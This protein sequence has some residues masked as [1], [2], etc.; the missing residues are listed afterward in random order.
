MG[1]GEITL[2]TAGA[3]TAPSVMTWPA[4]PLVI[5]PAAGIWTDYTL[6]SWAHLPELRGVMFADGIN[7]LRLIVEGNTYNAGL[8]APEDGPTVDPDGAQATSTLTTT[9]EFTDGDQIRLGK[10]GTLVTFKDTLPNLPGNTLGTCVKRTGTVANTLQNLEDLVMGTGVQ[11]VDYWDDS[12]A[13]GLGLAFADND[14]ITASATATTC[15]FTA[16][17]FGT[18][19]NG[20]WTSEVTDGGGGTFSFNNDPFM[21]SGAVTTSTGTGPKPGTYLWGFTSYRAVDG[22][23]SGMS[24][25]TED[26]VG[27]TMDVDLSDLDD[28]ADTSADFTRWYRSASG[29]GVLRLGDAIARGGGGTATDNYADVDL[30]G[31][32]EV[33]YDPSA[34]RSFNEGF[35]P[36][37]R[38]IARYQGRTFGGGAVLSAD[39]SIGTATVALNSNSVTITGGAVTRLWEGRT[40]TCDSKSEQYTIVSATPSTLPTWGGTLKLDR[41]YEV[42]G[43]SGKSYT[44]SD[45]RGRN[46]CTLFWSEPLQPSR[47]PGKNSL[48]AI[49]SSHPEGIMGMV[50]YQD[51]LV[52]FTRTGIWEVTPSAFSEFQARNRF[53]GVG[54]IS[55]HAIVNAEG[56]LYFA[57]EDGIYR[58]AGHLAAPIKVTSPPIT[59]DGTVSGIQTTWNRVSEAHA[60]RIFGH[61]DPQERVISWLLPLDGSVENNFRLNLELQTFTWS[62]DTIEGDTVMATVYDSDGSQVLL[63]GTRAGHVK[64]LGVGTSDGA[65]GVEQ[66]NTLT[67]TSTRTLTV[68]GASWTTDQFAG[69]PLWIVSADGDFTRATIASNTS[70]VLTLTE[71]IS[72]PGN[73][74]IVVGGILMDLETGRSHFGD[75]GARRTLAAVRVIHAVDEDGQYFL[76]SARDQDAADVRAIASGTLTA[77]DGETRFRAHRVGRFQKIRLLCIEPGCEPEF[78]GFELEV[79]PRDRERDL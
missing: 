20:Y 25:T 43:G 37:V 41:D 55:G 76:A 42:T 62:L 69:C 17:S 57:A 61:Y 79:R 40:F 19:G 46:T 50:P 53:E 45:A 75:P 29:S 24:P 16:T 14:D 4:S 74:Q 22:A 66:V 35:P 28:N 56:W 27:T 7:P 18:V 78:L 21:A 2:D 54:S 3:V 51:A 36:R 60:H 23:E 77:T 49:T 71:Y 13:Q 73:V 32:G 5:T 15:V 70:T 65:W 1:I 47:W 67:S 31:V 52:V 11:G 9:A 44:V 30:A 6:I 58:W 63:S 8:L 34:H 48:D 33:A 10:S 64:Q 26:Y 38:Y 68:S 72:D 12:Q 59:Q 39:Y